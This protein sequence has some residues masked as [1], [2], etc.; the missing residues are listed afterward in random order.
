VFMVGL[1]FS[2]VILLF[3]AQVAYA[4]QNRRTYM[5]QKQV[6]SINQRGREFVALRIMTTVGRRFLH[7]EPPQSIF[8]MGQELSVPTQLIQQIMQTLCAA[9][10]LVETA[11]ADPSYLPARPLE[12]IT[13]HDILL[14]MRAAH[15]Q[16]LAARDEKSHQDV[17]G[18]F[19]RIQEAERHVAQSITLLALANRSPGHGALPE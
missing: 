10:I 4:F 16:E 13:C 1:Y 6:E 7:G 12:R 2:W 15:G 17:Y 14:A 5:E 9:H 19:N 11:G 8:E 18:E 3:G